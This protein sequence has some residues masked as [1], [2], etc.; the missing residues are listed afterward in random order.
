MV[1]P[2]PHGD[3]RFASGVGARVVRAREYLKLPFA[4]LAVLAFTFFASVTHA[5]PEPP[6]ATFRTFAISSNISEVF[7]ELDGKPVPVA[8]A[9]AGL[10]TPYEVPTGGRVVFYRLQPAETSGGKPHRLTVAEVRLNGAGPFLVF[11]APKPGAPGE[12]LAQVVEDSWQTHPA[13]TIRLFNFSRRDVA[14]RIVI[15]EVVAELSP[16]RDRVL[17]YPVIGQF[18]M[19][20]ATKESTGWV[21]RVSAPQVAPPKARITAIIFDE[22][23]SPDRPVTH[24]LYLVKFIDVEPPPPAS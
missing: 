4:L 22:L 24:E 16:G 14:A 6:R 17:P 23:P 19:Q 5:Q 1:K 9:N 20:A 8:A 21:I 11:M 3:A 7:Y 10:S 12:V 15:K 18:W 2:R 13:E